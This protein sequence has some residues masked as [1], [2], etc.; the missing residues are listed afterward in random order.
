MNLFSEIEGLHGENLASAVLR[1]LI[2]RSVELRD[3]FVRLLSR[4]SPVGPLSCR[5]TF[6]CKCEAHTEDAEEG[7]GRV[8]LLLEVDETVIG[9]E[10]KFHAEF[11][12]G[13]PHK[14]LD[15]L[16][17]QAEGLSSLR[18][19]EPRYF[20]VVLAP[21]AREEESKE[22]LVDD[23]Q[24]TFLSW[25]DTQEA[26]LECRE[27]LDRET[28]V[29]LDVFCAY[30]RDRLAF[31][32]ELEEWL[33]HLRREFPPR[34]SSFQRY[35]LGSIWQ[36][37]P[38]QGPKLGSGKTWAGYYFWDSLK[39]P[40]GW[41]GFVP[42]SVIDPPRHGGAELIIATSV[43]VDL[44]PKWFK[45]VS[46]TGPAALGAGDE[47]RSWIVDFGP[48]WN[49]PSI[50]RERLEPLWRLDVSRSG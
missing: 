9:V 26:L 30:L 35:M 6:G 34:G 47:E 21:E 25:E 44:D 22:N 12:P 36:F 50:W 1:L 13:Q 45:P 7:S 43:K 8:D 27:R 39:E 42:S 23:S 28:L 18:R 4:R 37:F 2:L 29:I 49:S 48:E 20:L 15:H 5:D 16:R 24:C 19:R 17:Q 46:I 31:L 33:P 14:Y 40:R 41:F 3:A 32:P 38:D 10:N 11:Q